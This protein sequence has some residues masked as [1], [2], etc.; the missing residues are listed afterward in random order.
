MIVNTVQVNENEMEFLTKIL[1]RELDK[2]EGILEL[3]MTHA[4]R[5]YVIDIGDKIYGL[6]EKF[7]G[8]KKAHVT[9]MLTIVR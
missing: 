2:A 9:P 8:V 6:L 4:E 3:S 7:G 5:N 1:Q